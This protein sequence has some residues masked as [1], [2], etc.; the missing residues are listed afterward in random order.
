MSQKFG[1]LIRSTSPNFD[2]IWDGT[3]RNLR[4]VIDRDEAK[5]WRATAV[6]VLGDKAFQKV[7]FNVNMRKSKNVLPLVTEGTVISEEISTFIQEDKRISSPLKLIWVKFLKKYDVVEHK[8]VVAF[9]E[10]E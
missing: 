4:N 3:D 7:D 9:K 6:Q 1:F 8:G 2:L 5:R 10:K